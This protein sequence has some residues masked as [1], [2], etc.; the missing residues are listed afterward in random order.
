MDALRVLSLAVVIGYH[1]LALF[2]SW[3]AGRYTDRTITALVPGVWPLTWL[4]DVLPLFLFVGGFANATSYRKG[5]RRGEGVLTFY[6]R[7][8]RRLVVPTLVLLGLWEGLALAGDLLGGPVGGA[9]LLLNVRNTAPFGQLWFIGVY[10]MQ[11]ALAPLTLR[12]HRRFGAGTVVVM[13]ALVAAA[14]S[15]AWATHSSAVLAVNFITVWT[16]PHQLGYFYADGRLQKPRPVSMI[17]MGAAGLAVLATLTSLPPYP[18]SLLDPSYRVLG[19]NAPTAP[20]AGQAL[21]IIAVAVLLQRP[22]GRWLARSRGMAHLVDEG[23]AAIMTLFLWHT[24]A[25]LVAV[26][27]LQPV[28]GVWAM[29]PTPGWWLARPLVAGASA[30]VLALMLLTARRVRLWIASARHEPVLLTGRRPLWWGRGH[31]RGV[32]PRGTDRG[33]R[34]GA[35]RGRR[36]RAALGFSVRR[37]PPGRP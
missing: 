31:R 22:A 26:L 34:P 36:H 3:S 30:V 2:P 23:N 21:A 25:F 35:R 27:A 10:L 17:A 13:L 16:I 28:P 37:H 6:R 1:W 5:A 15:L 14:D 12:L 11:I 4:I 24:G 33:I 20:L 18:R 19:I 9:P 8:F 32:P 29:S 7:R